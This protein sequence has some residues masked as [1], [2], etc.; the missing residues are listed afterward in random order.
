MPLIADTLS[1]A[2]MF[3]DMFG[4]ERSSVFDDQAANIF[5]SRDAN[6]GIIA[7]YTGNSINLI[8]PNLFCDVRIKSQANFRM[9]R[10]EWVDRCQAGGCSFGHISFELS[11]QL[12]Y[13]R[14]PQ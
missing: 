13:T 5:I 10:Y 1:N 2:N 14:F 6:V 3:R 11:N 12:Y 8:E 7:E 9:C 4:F